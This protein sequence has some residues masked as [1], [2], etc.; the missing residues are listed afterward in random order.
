MSK[1][2]SD[3]NQIVVR[4]VGD[5]SDKIRNELNVW[6]EENKTQRLWDGD[7]SLWTNS[8]EDKWLGWLN[9]ALNH[10]EVPHIENLHAEIINKGI[11]DIVVLGMGGSSL[12]PAMLGEIFGKI[13]NNPRLRVL[14]STDPEQIR[15]LEQSIELK[16]T[17]FIVSSKS[18]TTLEPNIFKDYFYKRLQTILNTEDVGDHFIAITD[19]GTP[20][21]TCAKKNGFKKIFYGE[22]SI[23]GRYSGLSNFGLVPFGLMGGKVKDFLDNV[24]PMHQACSP[25]TNVQNNSGVTLGVILGICANNAKNKV[26]LIVSPKIRS[27]GAWLE[28]LLAESTGKN[29]KGL[30]PVDQEPL[31]SP[32]NYDDDRIFVYI[33]LESNP[34]LKQDQAIDSLEQAGFSIIRLH[35]PSAI[36]LGAEMFRWEIATAVAGSIIGINPFNQPN[37]EESKVL[38]LQLTS[39]YEKNGRLNSQKPFLSENNLSLFNDEHIGQQMK[40]NLVAYFKE[41]FNQIVKGDYVD[42]AA[43]I[44]MSNEHISILQEIR[45]LIRNQKKVAT[46]LGFGPRFLHSTGQA[47][48]GGPNCGIFLQLTADYV[49]D[50]QVPQHQYTF[51]IVIRAQAQADFSVLAKHTKRI[52][53]VDLG[54]NLGETLK[55]L[56]VIIQSALSNSIIMG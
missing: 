47:Y 32:T 49:R 38:T 4:Y 9:I 34:D 50:I 11:T 40:P 48:K 16:K 26:T 15:D 2:A 41:F 7:K 21:E 18:G 36:F 39:E 28:Q 45:T 33:R 55:E 5:Y 43:F 44:N 1:C 35:V 53:R 27:L 8:D 14:D 30:I 52:L 6:Q 17:L 24:I 20:L 31:G 12:C 37:V 54:D 51:G 25:R 23:G 22:P 3:K 46:C 56:K 42:L 13:G 29:G 10:K 19:P